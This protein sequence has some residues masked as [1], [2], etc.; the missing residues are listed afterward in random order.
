MSN[1]KHIMLA[2]PIEEDLFKRD[3]DNSQESEVAW[4]MQAS[5][6]DLQIWAQN[7]AVRGP[8]KQIKIDDS[9]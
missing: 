6:F 4:L 1:S 2:G 8:Q 7:V 3:S 5:G 9:W